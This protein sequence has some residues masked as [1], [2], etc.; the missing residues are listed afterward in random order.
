[1]APQPIDDSPEVLSNLL[2]LIRRSLDDPA[3]ATTY[4]D[5]ADKVLIDIATDNL[6]GALCDGPLLMTEC[7]LHSHSFFQ[8]QDGRGAEG[9]SL[10]EG[11]G[12]EVM[13]G[14][15]QSLE[16]MSGYRPGIFHTCST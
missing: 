12:G 6:R 2:Y 7:G 14:N 5:F 15:E 10:G 1:M 4:R 13:N 3:K 16:G 11:E 8:S 9:P